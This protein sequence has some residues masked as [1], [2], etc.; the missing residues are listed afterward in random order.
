MGTKLVT[1]P[2][3]RE[4]FRPGEPANE[5]YLVPPHRSTGD[6]TAVAC[7]AA[8]A[9]D[10]AH[11]RDEWE[12]DDAFGIA[13]LPHMLPILQPPSDNARLQSPDLYG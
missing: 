11:L 10:V 2:M 6:A 9:V 8:Q 4:R 3:Q 12:S 5:F 13:C 1:I 7:V